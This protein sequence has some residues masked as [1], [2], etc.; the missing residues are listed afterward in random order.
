M[1]RCGD[2]WWNAKS[3]LLRS[4]VVGHKKTAVENIPTAV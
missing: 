2:H 1:Q 3:N 4:Y